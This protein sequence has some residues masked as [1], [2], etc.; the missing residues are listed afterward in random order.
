MIK[1]KKNSVYAALLLV[2]MLLMVISFSVISVLAQENEA[3]IIIFSSTG[4][5]TNPE[6]GTY[7]YPEG[8]VINLEAT[9]EEGFEFLF[10]VASGEFTPGATEG[11]P[12]EVIIDG[13]PFLIPAIPTIDYLTF[14]EN[15]AEIT[16]GFGYTYEYQAVFAPIV[17]GIEPPQPAVFF[18]PLDSFTAQPTIEE[19]TFVEVSS[20]VGG[21]T[22]PDGGRY[23]F[24]EEVEPT[25]TMTATPDEGFEFQ[26]WIVTGDY[27]PGHGGDPSLDTNVIP[28]NPLE[29]THGR[30]YTYNYQAVF[31]PIEEN[32][33]G[34]GDGNGE[35]EPSVSHPFGLSSEL[36]TALIVILVI[37]VIV[38]I[39][40][41]LYMYTKRSK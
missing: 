8:T 5:T 3:T 39:L 35:P 29:V 26:H 31:T 1:T 33:D 27:M 13:E 34:N 19:I 41:G 14:T 37:A 32:G 6:A 28:N 4:G 25:F 9:P 30:G 36:L 24:G 12:N 40:F 22:T 20:T 11:R 16:C 23:L 18:D 38:A 7:T 10:W 15:P 21:T 17:S 2:A